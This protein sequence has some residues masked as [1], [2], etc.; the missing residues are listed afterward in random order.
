MLS[1]WAGKL[2][3]LPTLLCGA[4]D[5][6]LYA[7]DPSG[8][9]RWETRNTHL[10]YGPFPACYSLAVADFSNP[11]EDQIAVGTHG[12]VSLY[13]AAGDFLR[14]TMVYAHAVKP[15]HV[16][17]FYGDARPSLLLNTWGGGPKLVD[18]VGGKARDAWFAVWGGLA[19]Y[20][21]P[22]D[23]GGE[24]YVAYGGLNGTACG[25]LQREPWTAGKRLPA[26]VWGQDSWY[27][28][29][30][31]ET[32]A[33]LVVDLDGDGR[34]EVLSGN[35]T[36]F[37]VSYDLA[38]KRR[39]AKL[40][41]TRPNQLLAADVNADGRPEILMAGEDPALTVFDR[42]LERLGEWTP[43]G[44]AVR[45]M[46]LHGDRLLVQT[47]GDTLETVSFGK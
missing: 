38:G 43:S 33:V 24:T 7:F 8:K 40:V 39:F 31:G 12:G 23:F 9:P 6:G 10:W 25:R 35:E 26:E 13:S 3:G 29:S 22:F 41:G 11:G 17:R 42:K 47:A 27:L 34:P 32:T 44:G 1:C 14:F 37:L 4:R 5:G 45:K 15:E 19:P 21:Q 28:A 18:P 46:W 30:D 2:G 16:V 36:G 20:L